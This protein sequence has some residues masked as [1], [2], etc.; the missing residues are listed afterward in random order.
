MLAA[1]RGDYRDA[2]KWFRLA[3][4]G[5]IVQAGRY[6]DQIEQARQ[7]GMVDILVPTTKK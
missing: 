5:G 6:L 3:Q 1:K 2:E 4:E 7:T